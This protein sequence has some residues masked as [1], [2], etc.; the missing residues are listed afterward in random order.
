[1]TNQSLTK[2]STMPR[3]LFI[4][5]GEFAVPVLQG[6]LSAPIELAGIVTQP[7]KPVG[8]EQELAGGPV[9]K[10]LESNPLSVPIFQPENL[11]SESQT[12]L[13]QTLPDLVVVAAYGQMVPDDMLTQPKWGA[14]N[15]HGSLLPKLRG[16]VPVPMA[17]LQGLAVTGVTIQQMVAELDAGPIYAQQEMAILPDDTTESLKQ[18][19]AEKGSEMLLEMLPDLF[20]DKLQVREQEHAQATFCYERDIAKEKAEIKFDTSVVTA[21]RMVRAFYPWPIAWFTYI[22]PGQEP[23]RI[24]IFKARLFTDGAASIS[25]THQELEVVRS[26]KHLLLVL[27]DGVLELE[28]LQM[29]SKNR[30]AASD[31]LFL[32]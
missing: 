12:I 3:V 2:T 16:A 1:M 18:R 17:I 28:E 27:Q 9:K 19:L 11:R 14:L 32:A 30:R 21:E 24:K 5:T 20:A 22:A 31:Y 6:L 4:G 13:Q 29:E 8:R 15:L 10:F 25:T 26:G 23:K 7:D